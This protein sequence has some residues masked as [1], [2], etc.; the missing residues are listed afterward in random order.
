MAVRLGDYKKN[1]QLDMLKGSI[2]HNAKLD[3][4]KRLVAEM[5]NL[6][7]LANDVYDTFYYIKE[8]DKDFANQLWRFLCLNKEDNVRINSYFAWDARCGSYVCISAYGI[9]IYHQNLKNDLIKC[10]N[11]DEKDLYRGKGMLL[12]FLS[13]Y[14][15]EDSILDKII[16]EL[17][18]LYTH[19]ETY[20]DDFFECVSA[21]KC[22]AV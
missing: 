2:I 16:E 12:D 11:C 1:K 10:F 13:K 14:D 6:V 4:I 3:T 7:Q 9:G 5:D 18:L 20:A 21:Y 8:N 15:L 17:Q 19:F 22:K